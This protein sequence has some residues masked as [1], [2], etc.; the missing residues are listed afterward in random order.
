MKSLSTN[1]EGDAGDEFAA[2]AVLEAV[3]NFLA[4][5]ADDFVEPDAA[6][7]G[8]KHRAFADTARLGVR[9]DERI[10]QIVPSANDFRRES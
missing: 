5:I 10:E 7:D 3:K 1:P 9:G 4:A 6:I 2:E 8:D